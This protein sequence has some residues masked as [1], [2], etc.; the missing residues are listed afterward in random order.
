MLKQIDAALEDASRRQGLTTAELVESAV[1]DFGLGAAGEKATR[2]G[3]ATA[4]VALRSPDRV[5]VRWETN[6]KS[7]RSMPAGVAAGH[8][9]GLRA[10]KAEV[11]ELRAALAAERAR[12]ESLFAEERSWP[13][14]RW[15]RLY[16]EHPVTGALARGLIWRFVERTDSRVG[17]PSPSGAAFT[18][19]DGTDFAPS[20]RARVELWHP[21]DSPADEVAAWRRF[22]VERT[23]AQPLKQ[24]FRE[25]YVLAPVERETRTYSNRFAAHIV[26]YG[27]IY[28][29]VKSRGWAVNALGPWDGGYE[30]IARREL[31]AE[32]IRAEFYYEL[33]ETQDMPLHP[34]L[35]A[36]DQVRFHRLDEREPLPLAE[37]PP[38]V[39]SEAMRDVDLFVSVSS[40]AADPE[41]IDRGENRYEDF[42]FRTSFGELGES[43]EVRRDALRYVLP[44]LAIA[45]RC[46]LEDRFLRVRGDLGT[47]RIHLGSGNVL[48]EPNDQYLCIVPARSGRKVYLPFEGDD[49]L[50]TILGKAFL[51]A[52]DTKISD[53]SIRAQIERR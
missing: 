51:L 16:L 13:L 43:A 14:D 17:F 36:T 23:L 34:D 29:V 48:M 46:E 24:A 3:E 7:T 8:A 44:S 10:L 26:R 49:R 4:T 21:I 31:G 40:I 52:R 41:W 18:S 15:R 33:V 5:E 22:L 19:P 6:G 35:A 50:A 20:K 2:L 28:A 39:F 25:V 47:Y 9:D 38:R 53:Q 32:R 1:P 30:A 45:D 12:L 42:W 11:R 37:V 27:Q